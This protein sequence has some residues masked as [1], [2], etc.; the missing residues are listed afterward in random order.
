ME[1][2]EGLIGEEILMSA[3]TTG[4]AGST[5]VYNAPAFWERLWRTSGLQFV[6]LF[7]IASLIYGYQPQVGASPE[8]LDAFYTGDRTRVLLA[9]FFS[10][11]N[12]LNLL[13]FTAALRTTLADAGLGRRTAPIRGSSRPSSS[14]CGSWW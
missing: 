1:L 9:S 14:S 6:A 5:S 3:S 2:R 7:I 13:W 8:A 12:L 11:L 4:P 10:G